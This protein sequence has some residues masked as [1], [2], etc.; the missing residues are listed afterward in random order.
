MKGS[1]SGGGM[2][3]YELDG[4]LDVVDPVPGVIEMLPKLYFGKPKPL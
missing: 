4:D 2:Q 1:V 3:V